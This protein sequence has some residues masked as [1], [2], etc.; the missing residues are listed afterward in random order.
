MHYVH[1][2]LLNVTRL[3]VLLW[4][5]TA[6]FNLLVQDFG[7]NLYS[8]FFSKFDNFY[9]MEIHTYYLRGFRACPNYNCSFNLI[10]P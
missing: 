10:F 9:L 8:I 1:C 5:A 2:L 4:L 6:S 3:R 7:D